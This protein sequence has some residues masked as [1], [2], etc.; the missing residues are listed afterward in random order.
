L[1]QNGRQFFIYEMNKPLDGYPR[2]NYVNDI[3]RSYG[4]WHLPEQLFDA[5]VDRVYARYDQEYPET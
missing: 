5:A 4:Q 3:G 2:E 1:T